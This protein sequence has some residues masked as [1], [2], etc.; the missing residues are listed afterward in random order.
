MT[1]GMAMKVLLVEDH[2]GFRTLF[3]DILRGQGHEV[4][5]A[6]NGHEGYRLLNTDE[7]A[8]TPYDLVVSDVQMWDGGSGFWLVR[9]MRHRCTSTAW[10]LMT[11]ALPLESQRYWEWRIASPVIDKKVIEG[12]LRQGV[13]EQRDIVAEFFRIAKRPP[14]PS[15]RRHASSLLCAEE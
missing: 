15:R 5:E 6:R 11:G 12:L 9:S 13:N 1:G 10:V 2:A 8:N 4:T 7:T 3:A 14:P